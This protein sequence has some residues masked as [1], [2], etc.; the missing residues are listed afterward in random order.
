MQG[1]TND[2]VDDAQRYFVSRKDEYALLCM[3]LCDADRR[4]TWYDISCAPT[5][6]DS[7]AWEATELGQR[8]RN[9][10]LPQP[11]FINADSAFSLSPSV[12]VPSGD[13]HHDD[14]DFHQSSNRMAIECTFGILVRRWGVLWRPLMVRFD[15]RAPLVGACIRLHNYCIDRRI[16]EVRYR[17]KGGLSRIQPARWA[18]TPLFDREGR[19][20]D[21]LK[22]ERGPRTNAR[23][24]PPST[25]YRRDQLVDIVNSSGLCRPALR[26]G[27]HQKKKR[28][29]GG[30][31]GQ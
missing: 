2:E 1:P 23:D 20:V 14:F 21:Y 18:A 26:Q 5:T 25:T 28:K 10:A 4:F 19:P 31:V 6:H 24:A 3:A 17:S 12:I 13:R 27:L 29:R 11:F 30:R 8:V 16:P 9:G 7:L 15:R 22:I